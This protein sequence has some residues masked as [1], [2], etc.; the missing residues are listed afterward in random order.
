M[1]VVAGEDVKSDINGCMTIFIYVQMDICRGG[2]ASVPWS[3]YAR[4]EAGVKFSAWD[5]LHIR[6]WEVASR[7]FVFSV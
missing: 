1:P 7:R 3:G 2:Q 6:D 5:L 4:L